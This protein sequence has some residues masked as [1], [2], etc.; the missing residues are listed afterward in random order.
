MTTN[1]RTMFGILLLLGAVLAA[2]VLYLRGRDASPAEEPEV[3]GSALGDDPEAMRKLRP[4]LSD[5]PGTPLTAAQKKA[6][7]RP[8][9]PGTLRDRDTGEVIETNL[10]SGRR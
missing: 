3:W 10:P 8:F 9:A 5:E 4:Y 7:S 1:N 2:G 6:L